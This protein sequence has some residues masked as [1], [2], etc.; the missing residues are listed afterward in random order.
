MM[1]Q[2][3]T[4]AGGRWIGLL[5]GRTKKQGKAMSKKVKALAIDDEANGQAGNGWAF[6]Q[7]GNG[8]TQWDA[9]T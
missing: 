3:D 5:A 7:L 9:R 6:G 1:R 4:Q 2:M 8:R